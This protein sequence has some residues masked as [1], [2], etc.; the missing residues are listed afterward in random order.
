MPTET[1]WEKA[2]EH[3]KMIKEEYDK[4]VSMPGVNATFA[5]GHINRDITRY[6]NG[7]RTQ[8]LYNELLSKC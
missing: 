8:E 2:V 6:A 1:E 4:L 7:E 3:A 5:L